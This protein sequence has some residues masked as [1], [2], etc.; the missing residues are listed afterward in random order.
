MLISN[1]TSQWLMDKEKAETVFA[2][3]ERGSHKGRLDTGLYFNMDRLLS[4]STGRRFVPYYA[5]INETKLKRQVNA[6]FRSRA[7]SFAEQLCHIQR[8]FSADFKGIRIRDLSNILFYV[9]YHTNR[10]RDRRKILPAVA[11]FALK[12]TGLEQ[13]QTKSQE[14]Q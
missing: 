11:R 7:P 9:W 6:Y 3:R 12:N 14:C 1:H 8:R 2:D 5:A 10:G 13:D 4:R